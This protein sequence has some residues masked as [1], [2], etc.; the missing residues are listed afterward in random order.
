MSVDGPGVSGDLGSCELTRLMTD[1]MATTEESQAG[2][3]AEGRVRS[4]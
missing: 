4:G 1:V 2:G 3:D